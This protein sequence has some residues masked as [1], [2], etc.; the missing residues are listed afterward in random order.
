M[1]VKVDEELSGIVPQYLS[2]RRDEI[3]DMKKAL[4]ESDMEGLRVIG[5][6]LKGSGGGYGFDYLTEVGKAIEVAAKASDAQEIVRQVQL[7]EEFLDQVEVV[8]E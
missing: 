8:Y 6:K 3:D 2:K 7:L 1:I 5:H 4:S